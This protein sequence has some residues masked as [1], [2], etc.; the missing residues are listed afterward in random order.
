ME[1]FLEV[2]QYTIP[3]LIVLVFTLIIVRWFLKSENDRRK[4]ELL[5][6]QNRDSLP[7]RIAAYERLT[8]FLERI[9]AESI[10]V[11]EQPSAR[12]V[13]DFQAI[14]LS[15]IRTEYEHNMAMQV[16]LPTSTWQLVR[17][18]KEEMIRT[19][20]IS[21]GIVKPTDPSIALGKT[22]LEQYP[23]GAAYHV[24]RALDALK[25]DVQSFYNI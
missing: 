11:R 4:Q 6:S 14:L 10:I 9:S 17:N 7:L 13:K 22:I 24:K 15:S 23:N 21:A 18:A 19:V 12:T 16:H 25:N 5:L 8:L 2:L 20:N 1:V 3:S